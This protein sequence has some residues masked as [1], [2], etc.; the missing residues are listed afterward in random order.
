MRLETQATY[1][2][3]LTGPEHALICRAIRSLYEGSGDPAAHQLLMELTSGSPDTG[4][5]DF[6][7]R[8]AEAEFPS[9][10]RSINPVQQQLAGEAAILRTTTV[11]VQGPA[12]QR[13]TPQEESA[14][15]AGSAGADPLREA[16]A[17]NVAAVVARLEQ[18][19]VQCAGCSLTFT[20]EEFKT[21]AHPAEPR[22]K[23]KR[24]GDE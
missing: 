14:M 10:T 2:L 24:K 4:T 15:L 23:P 22:R 3:E 9:S 11:E 12:P 16:A 20:D 1:R 8:L 7:K 18:P 13:L 5:A 17:R 6:S 21:H 19:L